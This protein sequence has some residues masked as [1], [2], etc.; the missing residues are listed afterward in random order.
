MAELLFLLGVSKHGGG[1]FVLAP[2]SLLLLADVTELFHGWLECTDDV[3]VLLVGSSAE[4]ADWLDDDRDDLLDWFAEDQDGLK[5]MSV[6]AGLRANDFLAM[7]LNSVSPWTGLS[8]ELRLVL[9]ASCETVVA[10]A[11]RGV[12]LRGNCSFFSCV[13]LNASGEV[14]RT[15]DDVAGAGFF[16][17]SRTVWGRSRPVREYTYMQYN[18][19]AIHLIDSKWHLHDNT[20]AVKLNFEQ[21]KLWNYCYF[22]LFWQ[23]SLYKK[24]L[25]YT[26]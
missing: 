21:S 8:T 3:K 23:I 2:T 9:E 4:L 5:S 22:N 7:G 25:D 14:M 18:S 15:L 1:D 19:H 20:Y 17:L 16:I 13:L 26:L 10:A 12:E 11:P 6:G 24:W